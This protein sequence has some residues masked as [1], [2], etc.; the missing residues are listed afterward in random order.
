MMAKVAVVGL[1]KLGCPL[2]AVLSS[3]GHRVF[4]VDT[5]VD[6]VENINHRQPPVQEPGL[7]ELLQEHPFRATTFF[8]KAI[9]TSDATF[10]V[11]PTPSGPDHQFLNDFVIKAVTQVG[12]HLRDK[13]HLVVV[14]STVMPGSMMGPIR[15]ALE[16]AANRPVGRDLGLCYSPEFIALGSV[17][18]DMLNPDMVLV[19]E[20]DVKAGDRLE[21]ILATV[22][23]A[24]VNRMRMIDAEIAKLAINTYVTMKISYANS[25]AEICEGI[26]EANAHAVVEAI[27]LDSRIGRKYLTPGTAF[28]GPCFP[29]D[30]KAFNAMGSRVKAIPWLASATELINERQTTRLTEMA[31]K[32]MLGR[33]KPRIGILGLS[34]KAQTC[35][36]EESAGVKLALALRNAGFSVRVFDPQVKD[37]VLDLEGAHAGSTTDLVAFSDLVFIMT[38]WPEFKQVFPGVFSD[39]RDL[40]VVDCW[41]VTETGPWDETN[42]IRIGVGQ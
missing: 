11:V 34:Y 18:Y 35:I 25:L 3:K 19:G 26:P 7:A 10:I 31:H 27:G 33:A 5:N 40:M 9:P 37:G 39:H 21:R 22:S 36:A 6:F 24:P 32:L 23:G 42:I 15:Q 28:G 1:G 14:C 38:P 17:I 41:N 8:E 16:K 29:R 2:A 30:T 12:E 4:G 20:S 13:Y